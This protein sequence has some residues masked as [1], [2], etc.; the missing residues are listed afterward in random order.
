MNDYQKEMETNY[1]I[2]KKFVYAKLREEFERTLPPVPG[3]DLKAFAES[4]GAIPLKDFIHE[5]E[6]T[7]S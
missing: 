3:D 1:P 7:D 6:S 4:E 5:I 2:F